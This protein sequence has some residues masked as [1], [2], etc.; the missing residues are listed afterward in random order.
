MA[1]HE[2]DRLT[3]VYNCWPFSCQSIKVLGGAL[4]FYNGLKQDC[5]NWY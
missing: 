2:D 1:M 3:A 4:I 5:I